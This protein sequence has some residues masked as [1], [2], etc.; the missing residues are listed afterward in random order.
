MNG[1]VG[2]LKGHLNGLADG[3]KANLNALWGKICAYVGCPLPQL[4][5]SAA[6]ERDKPRKMK[7]GAA[8]AEIPCLT[9][10]D[11]CPAEYNIEHLDKII[12]QA[13]AKTSASL[14][15]A[16]V[17]VLGL[18]AQS[19]LTYLMTRLV[20]LGGSSQGELAGYAMFSMLPLL[21]GKLPGILAGSLAPKSD[22]E[23]IVWAN[24]HRTVIEKSKALVETLPKQ[25]QEEIHR[26]DA[27]VSLSLLQLAGGGT[28]FKPPSTYGSIYD[29]LI[30]R[31]GKMLAKPRL[32]FNYMERIDRRK[33]DEF[34][35]TQPQDDA[36]FYRMVIS[37]IILDSSIQSPDVQRM[38][39][40]LHGEPGVGKSYQLQRLFDLLEVPI[41]KFNTHSVDPP[42]FLDDGDRTY[43]ILKGPG[44]PIRV[45][46]DHPLADAMRNLGYKNPVLFCEEFEANPRFT[47]PWLVAYIKKLF[48][49]QAKPRRPGPARHL[50]L[51]DQRQAAGVRRRHSQQN[52]GA[53][54]AE[55]HC[56]AEE[57]TASSENRRDRGDGPAPPGPRP[58]PR[59]CRRGLPAVW[60]PWSGRRTTC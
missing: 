50:L 13:H 12:V 26:L 24:I 35:A 31:Q 22:V 40:L 6:N 8:A 2:S 1:T 34:L 3:L 4:A 9:F 58:T 29:Y 52:A 60:A 25:E 10:E 43:K 49:P 28:P 5:P 39:V 48:D 27:R 14:Q 46:T 17:N 51:H 36:L 33:L 7:K 30:V 59:A 42:G 15:A 44:K 37:K 11:L 23:A 57:D 47:T 18:A 21:S 38:Q 45:V 19:L 53:S 41:I 55:A 16:A 54:P 20:S 56:G 32:W